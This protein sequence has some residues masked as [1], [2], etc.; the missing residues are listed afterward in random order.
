MHTC[1][2]HNLCIYWAIQVEFGVEVRLKSGGGP[3]GGVR[4]HLRR[5]GTCAYAMRYSDRVTKR[6]GGLRH[7]RKCPS[8][9]RRTSR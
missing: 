8:A 4:R 9:N 1:A 3:V 6:L 7:L 2:P 5:F